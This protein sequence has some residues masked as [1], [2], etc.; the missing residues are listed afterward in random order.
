MS[1][2]QSFVSSF[3]AASNG[4]LKGKPDLATARG[5][6][7]A[8]LK[9]LFQLCYS[10]YLNGDFVRAQD[11]FQL[12]CIY[13]HSNADNWLGYGY[14]LM[15][16]RNFEK[17]AACL[18]YAS[19]FVEENSNK[20]YELHYYLGQSFMHIGMRDDAAAVLR[21]IVDGEVNDYQGRA[22]SLLG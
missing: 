10:L 13:D 3:A 8:H 17:A 18:A 19:L 5:I 20:W 12:L 15:G 9:D 4:L 22:E 11:C 16:T 21:L 6:D 14:A 1:A 2:D 7:K